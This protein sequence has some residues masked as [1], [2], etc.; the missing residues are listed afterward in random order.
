MRFNGVDG[1]IQISK[2]RVHGRTPVTFEFVVTPRES[3]DEYG[4]LLSNYSTVDGKRNGLNV[5][6]WRGYWVGGVATDSGN[7]I[8]FSQQPVVYGSR[9]HL[10]VV[11][12]PDRIRMFING[13]S[14]GTPIRLAQAMR[15]SDEDFLIAAQRS[16]RPGG[17]LGLRFAGDLEAVRVSSANRFTRDFKPPAKLESDDETLLLYDFEEKEADQVTDRSLFSFH[18]EISGAAWTPNREQPTYDDITQVEKL[19]GIYQVERTLPGNAG[20][21]KSFLRLASDF[22]VLEGGKHVGNWEVGNRGRLA[23]EMKDDGLGPVELKPGRNGSLSGAQKNDKRRIDWRAQRI[24]VPILWRQLQ[25]RD[26]RIQ[27][28]VLIVLYSNG[29][30]GTHDGASTW[31]MNRNKLYYEWDNGNKAELTISPDGRQYQGTNRNGERVV[32]RRVN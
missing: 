28:N 13:K 32:G 30:I 12:E 9:I 8:L 24:G 10:A 4:L 25:Y 5:G 29:R 2:L 17:P 1:H 15:Y 31:K 22:R 6:V 11:F 21:F 27:R 3:K 18:G 14:A 19:V 26:D 16:T 20:Q 7:Q 23:L